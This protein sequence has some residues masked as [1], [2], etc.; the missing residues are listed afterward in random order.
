MM[1]YLLDVIDEIDFILKKRD[2]A[3]KDV[4]QRSKVE[5]L[6]RKGQTILKDLKRDRERNREFSPLY[7][8]KYRDLYGILV[9]LRKNLAQKLINM[10]SK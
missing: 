10:R 8:K 2:K 4:L 1:R 6:I 9:M 3:E 7:T 5:R